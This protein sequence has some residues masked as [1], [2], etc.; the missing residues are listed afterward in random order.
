M[1]YPIFQAISNFYYH[2]HPSL[3]ILSGAL[4][5]IYN[6]SLGISVAQEQGQL[7]QPANKEAGISNSFTFSFNPTLL[8]YISQWV[9]VVTDMEF[10]IILPQAQFSNLPAST[11]FLQFLAYLAWWIVKKWLNEAWT[12][13]FL[14]ETFQEIGFHT[15]SLMN[16][17][18]PYKIWDKSSASYACPCP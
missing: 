18:Y 4:S 3:W 14:V 1:L 2:H 6:S 16:C 9:C 11:K 13:S 7:V 12:N 17:T 8:P 5:R 10:C 15:L